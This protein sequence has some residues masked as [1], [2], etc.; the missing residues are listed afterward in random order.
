[1]KKIKARKW[2]SILLCIVLAFSM[3]PV[4]TSAAEGDVEYLY[5]DENGENWQTG[6]K[7]DGE[8]TLATSSD[9]SWSNGWYVVEGSITNSN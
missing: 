2:L 1:M 8:Y 6:I 5:C 4:A 7:A 3:F 9:T